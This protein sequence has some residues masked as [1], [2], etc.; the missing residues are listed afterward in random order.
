MSSNRLI[1]GFVA[2]L[3]CFAGWFS[4]GVTYW[5]LPNHA[6]RGVL[7]FCLILASTVVALLVFRI[8][9]RQG[10][11]P[12]VRKTIFVIVA[13]VFVI[14]ISSMFVAG[15]V[16]Y[17]RFGLTVY[18]LIP[19]PMLDVTVNKHGLLWFRPKSHLATL[20]EV[21]NLVDGDVEVLVIGTG[22]HGIMKVEDEVSNYKDLDVRILKTP[23][24]YRV[25]NQ[26]KAAGTKVV[27][28][29]HSTC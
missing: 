17:A 5:Y 1:A 4:A 10:T 23:D 13:A 20:S 26:L 7:S 28:L 11:R 24:A 14:L 16:T 21:R 29:A 12:F 22:W 6:N 18:G 3:L 25:F 19:V 9:S 8:V 15:Q 2:F 27:L